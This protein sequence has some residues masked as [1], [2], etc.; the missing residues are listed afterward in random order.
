MDKHDEASPL[1]SSLLLDELKQEL[2]AQRDQLDRAVGLSA[3]AVTQLARLAR[4]VYSGQALDGRQKQA[5]DERMDRLDGA[6]RRFAVL[7]FDRWTAEDI[8]RRFD[9]PRIDAAR[10]LLKAAEEGGAPL[11][12]RKDDSI[13]LRVEIPVDA[14]RK[15]VK[16]MAKEAGKLLLVGI[17]TYIAKRLGWLP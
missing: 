10:R 5:F 11:V 4:A 2:V 15:K 3:E 9:K 17:G 1:S 14:G 8:A 6:M 16:K 13:T 7:A 12:K